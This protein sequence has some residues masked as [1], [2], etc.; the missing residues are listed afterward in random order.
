MKELSYCYKCGKALES[1]FYEG[2]ERYYCP[3]CGETRFRNSVPVAGV[4]V[5]EG[6]K[7][8]MIKRGS[9]P[10]RGKWSY[11]AG[12]LEFDEK[13]EEGAV[14]ELEEETGL[15]ADKGT[16]K[17]VS[18]IHLEHPDK[19][20]VGNAYATSFEDV[21][22]E[23]VAGDDAEEAEFWTV[24]EMRS[25]IKDIESPKIVEAAGRAIRMMSDQVN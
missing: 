17:L 21:E 18:S 6:D 23:I 14:R 24:K 3:K 11:P 19:Y 9:D 1:R 15:K 2:R 16:M 25:N 10:H 13:P 20:V 22:G 4:F 5:V 7:V 8:L 12:Y